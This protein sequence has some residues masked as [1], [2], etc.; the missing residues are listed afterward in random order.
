MVS[1]GAGQVVTACGREGGGV[2]IR[3]ECGHT[4]SQV[5]RGEWFIGLM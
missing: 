3:G 5:N 1:V 2:V 4:C